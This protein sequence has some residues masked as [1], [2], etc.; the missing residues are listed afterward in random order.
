MLL[1]ILHK[2]E[3][4]G[5]LAEKWPTDKVCSGIVHSFAFWLWYYSLKFL[6]REGFKKLNAYFLA[7]TWLNTHFSYVSL[8]LGIFWGVE[9]PLFPENRERSKCPGTVGISLVWV[10]RLQ[11]SVHVPPTPPL[12]FHLLFTPMSHLTSSSLWYRWWWT[13]LSLIH[14]NVLFGSRSSLKVDIRDLCQL[15]CLPFSESLITWVWKLTINNVSFS[16][17]KLCK[18]G[19]KVFQSIRIW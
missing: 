3:F 8:P 17:L 5:S 9:N 12:L 15:V 6:F 1:W 19:Y 10:G 16:I 18:A 7:E 13:F 14:S 11:E 2:I 4:G